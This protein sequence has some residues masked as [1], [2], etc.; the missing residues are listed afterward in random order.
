[1]SE[2]FTHIELDNSYIEAHKKKL[3]TLDQK[4]R[5]ENQV[6]RVFGICKSIA[7]V[8]LALGVALFFILWGISLLNKPEVIREIETVRDVQIP[9][10]RVIHENAN[11]QGA[12]VNN[13]RLSSLTQQEESKIG[14]DLQS[15]SENAASDNINVEITTFEKVSD[16][17]TELIVM[18]GRAFHPP[19]ENG[20]GLETRKWC[21]ALVDNPDTNVQ[22]WVEFYPDDV[23]K[24]SYVIEEFDYDR[25]KSMC[26]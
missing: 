12:V 25:L 7:L 4:K 18:T 13:G 23:Y 3:D 20:L 14:D 16:P 26:R 10:I 2:E 5:S 22:I 6:Y 24:N 21:Y 15:I 19:F 8:I 1:M 9:E 11:E 17:E